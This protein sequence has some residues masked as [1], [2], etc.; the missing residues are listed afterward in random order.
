MKAL[1]I[2]LTLIVFISCNEQQKEF[3]NI[4]KGMNKSEVEAIA[5]E[6]TKKTNVGLA[7]LWT[8][9]SADRTIVFRKDT[10][11]NII[12]SSEARIDSLQNK[13]ED[14]GQKIQEGAKETG[15][16]ITEGTKKISDKADTLLER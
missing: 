3:A 10:V 4:E 14:A 5:G 15:K 1:L 7:E 12:T 9:D 16:D 11:F 13:V 6:P 8:Y 2:F